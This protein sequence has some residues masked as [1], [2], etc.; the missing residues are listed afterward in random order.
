LLAGES[1][2]TADVRVEGGKAK[3]NMG[4]KTTE[5]EWRS[6][7]EERSPV[8]L[9]APS[10][11]SWFEVWR[12]DVSPV[13]HASFAGIP[14]VHT[15]KVGGV[16]IPEWHPWPGEEAKIEL[17]RP[18]GEPGQTF[19]IDE[20]T[21]DVRP[22]V[23][24][25][26]V[27]LSLEV[28]S[29]R[30][31]EHTFVLPDGAQL[32]SLSIR[33]ASQPLRQDGRRVT[34]PLVPGAQNISLVWRQTPGV[35]SFFPTP[36]VDVGA[37]S[38]NASTQIHVPDSR[39]VLWVSGPRVGP[40]V[41][42]WGLLAVLLAVSLALGQS[43]LTPMQAWQWFLLAIGLSQVNVAAGAVFVGWLF[44]LGFRGRHHG[45]GLSAS[46]FN[47]R[48]TLIVLWTVVALVILAVSL[49]QGL[50]GA[51]EMQL[52]G[53]G[54]T[55][56]MLRWFTDRSKPVL[57]RASVVSVPLMVYRGA[58]LAWALWIALALLGWLKWG[59]ASFSSGGAWRRPPPRR[60]PSPPQPAPP[61]VP[62]QESQTPA[63]S[64]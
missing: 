60:Y 9:A 2:T 17:V 64:Q 55:A 50:L 13:W 59:W 26:D 8:K 23:R 38:V 10:S 3:V 14:T 40:A 41:L 32:E 44:V 56:E 42:F 16:T 31:D 12:A 46:V 19:T 20:S 24:A 43:S 28:R 51:P 45:D 25:T 62:E 4:A 63:G 35:A 61:P 18:Q 37:P 57:P 30:G 11:I 6:V 39:W 27:T 52:A 58:M 29:S 21:L 7:L 49:Y 53:N 15:A 36:E 34:V 47:L 54:S 22:G 48:Q 5:I 1:V 33:G